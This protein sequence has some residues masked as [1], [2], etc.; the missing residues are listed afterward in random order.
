MAQQL[1][2]AIVSSFNNLSG[3]VPGTPKAIVNRCFFPDEFSENII[4]MVFT[5]PVGG[6]AAGDTVIICWVGLSPTTFSLPSSVTDTLGTTWNQ[7]YTP[8]EFETANSTEKT[9]LVGWLAVLTESI[10]F[11][12]PYTVD[13][14]YAGDGAG[15]ITAM[16]WPGLGPLRQVQIAQANSPATSVTPSITT[17]GDAVLLAQV[18]EQN[19]TPPTGWSV[20][21]SDHTATQ[22]YFGSPSIQTIGT[23]SG[24]FSSS[25]FFMN[26]GQGAAI[27]EFEEA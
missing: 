7:I 10:A 25:T 1:I 21:G 15:E 9:T 3:L 11:G 17:S 12:S 26:D 13:I 22:L 18:F 20:A 14:T 19:A 6:F 16:V 5:V 27:M 8:L 4:P 2:Q 24:T 23:Y